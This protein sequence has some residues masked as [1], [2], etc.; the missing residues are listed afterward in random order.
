MFAN[1]IKDNQLFMKILRK[2]NAFAVV[3]RVYPKDFVQ[4]SYLNRTDLTK[5]TLFYSLKYH[6]KNVMK[7]KLINPLN[8]LDI[9]S[10]VILC[11]LL[12]AIFRNVFYFEVQTKIM[13]LD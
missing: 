12:F 8:L 3:I 7:Y 4:T 1:A 2:H 6:Q 13:R 11:D 10:D 9:G 5:F